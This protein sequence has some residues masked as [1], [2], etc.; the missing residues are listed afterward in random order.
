MRGALLTTLLLLSIQRKTTTTKYK[1]PTPLPSLVASNI[2]RAVYRLLRNLENEHD[3][4]EKHSH[5][6]SN[7]SDRLPRIQPESRAEREF[8][9]AIA[10]EMGGLV[11]GYQ[12]C[13]VFVSTSQPVF[14]REKFLKR[15]PALFIEE[16]TGG[17]IGSRANKVKTNRRILSSRSKRFLSILV[18]CQ[19]FH[20]VSGQ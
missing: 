9:I 6:V 2:S 11:R 19:H 8:R 7:A 20:Q 10:L 13:L 12:D 15:A 17:A 5:P 14:N 3:S 16:P 4:E 1:S 18:N